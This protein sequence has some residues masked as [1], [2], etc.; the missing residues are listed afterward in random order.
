MK[1]RFGQK[2]LL[3]HSRFNR[4][5]RDRIEDII[6]GKSLPKVLVAT[7]MIEVSLDVDFEQAFLEP[8]PIDALIQRMGRVN[9]S[10]QRPPARVT[11][12]TEQVNPN[13]LYCECQGEHHQR[14]C[15]IRTTINELQKLTN[16][17]S[18]R[19]LVNAADRV[20]GEGYQGKDKMAFEEGLHHPDIEEFENNLLAGAHQDWV[21]E[22]IEK[23]DGVIEVLPKCL[24]QEYSRR[25]ENGLWIE[26]N[27]LLVPVRIGSLQWLM[28]RVDT[29]TDPWTI[30]LTY[31]SDIGL[32][33]RR[34]ELTQSDNIC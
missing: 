26:A 29:S 22:I 19:D 34:T 11:I 31:A 24:S 3:L 17:I 21:E 13:N 14:N 30:D 15:R 16:P 27:N 10:G 20:Y 25:R 23:T 2:A 32:E 7:Q 8:A 18:E 28:S 1:K 9:R 5:D 33:L 4:E 6:L 12:F